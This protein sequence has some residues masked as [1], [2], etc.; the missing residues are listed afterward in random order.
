M[1]SIR[2]ILT[3]ALLST[4]VVGIAASNSLAAAPYAHV[5]LISIDGMHAIDLAN[6]VAAHPSST[7]AALTNGA[8]STTAAGKRS[9]R[10]VCAV[11][12]ASA[13]PML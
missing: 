7:L 2:H 8:I 1:K 12:S 13:H 5:L 3:S 10:W 11:C 6:Y 4:A 9:P